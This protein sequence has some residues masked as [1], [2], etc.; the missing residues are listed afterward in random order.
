MNGRVLAE[1]RGRRLVIE[2]NPSECLANFCIVDR[3]G[4]DYS[5]SEVGRRLRLEYS[6][7]ALAVVVRERD[8]AIHDKIAG[9]FYII[10]K[11]YCNIWAVLSLVTWYDANRHLWG[12]WLPVIQ[13]IRGFREDC[14]DFLRGKDI[15][16]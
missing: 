6:R 10:P 1:A 2:W 5:I 7:Y 4:N 15:F 8:I 12:K 9:K 3:E 14:L 16:S 13:I 11:T